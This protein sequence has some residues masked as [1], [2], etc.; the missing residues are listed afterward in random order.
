[1]GKFIKKT[2]DSAENNDYVKKEWDSSEQSE[3]K[4]RTAAD[5]IRESAKQARTNFTNKVRVARAEARDRRAYARSP[6]GK[7][8]A[9]KE[10]KQQYQYESAKYKLSKV[11]G[12]RRKAQLD[13]LGMFGM[14]GGGGSMGLGGNMGLGKPS[15]T[16]FD[17]M[18]GFGGAEKMTRMSKPK[19]SGFDEMFGF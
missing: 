8:A 14:G 13:S 19:K 17:S 18:F 7:A 1:M 15:Y 10:I 12:Q 16:G 11:R 6:E 4:K 3:I 5:R 2:W 9:L